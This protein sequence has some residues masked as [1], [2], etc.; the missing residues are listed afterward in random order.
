MAVV[1]TGAVSGA[2]CNVLSGVDD[3]TIVSCPGGCLDAAGLADAD[4]ATRDQ[5]GP[6]AP[7]ADRPV[8][9]GTVD[10]HPDQSV[11][12]TVPESGGVDAPADIVMQEA[13]PLRWCDMQTPTPSF[14]DDF[15]VGPL[16]AT[17]TS[18]SMD[19]STLSLDPTRSTSPPDSCLVSTQAI[20]SGEANAQLVK[21]FSTA[22][23]GTMQ[24]AFD[25]YLQQVDTTVS[26]PKLGAIRLSDGYALFVQLTFGS[27]SVVEAIPEPDGG[28]LYETWIAT[29][30]LPVQQWVRLVLETQPS[31]TGVIGTYD[32]QM[33][34]VVVL[35]PMQAGSPGTSGDPEIEI[36][37]YN[38]T[39]PSGAWLVSFDDVVFDF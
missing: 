17:W 6:D 37:A 26:Y 15:D 36:G 24:L 19:F 3:L 28:T 29:Q 35:G 23:S 10:S 5:A 22:A 8:D 9:T 33:G 12:S 20:M 30:N 4:A 16:G 27:L 11:D 21:T 39:A 13:A 32:L 7:T 14:C 1:I 2:A 31:S 38:I 18:M 25:V 34:G